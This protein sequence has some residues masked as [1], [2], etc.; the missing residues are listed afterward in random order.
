MVSCSDFLDQEPTEQRSINEQ[1]S[2]KEL[3]DQAVN[4]LYKDLESLLSHRYFLYADL[5]GGNFTFAPDSKDNIIEVPKGAYDQVYDFD[6]KQEDSDYESFYEGAYDVINAANLILEHLPVMDFIGENKLNQIQAEVLVVRGFA[7]YMLTLLYA[8]NYGYTQDASHK[9]VV[10]NT[11][12][13]KAGV[14][15]PQRETLAENWEHIQADINEAL[16]L[17]TMEQALGYG[18]QYSYFNPNNTKALYAKMALQM[19]N[20]EKAYSFAN[21]VISNSGVE[22][23]AKEEL[24]AE[25]KKEAEPVSE[26]LLEFS[27]SRDGDGAIGYSVSAY[28]NYVDDENYKR[29]VASDDLL[30]LYA[31]NDI[32]SDLF[33]EVEIETSVDSVMYELPYYFTWKFQ[34]EPGTLYLR[35]TEMYFIRAE[36]LARLGTDMNAALN[37]LNTIRERA[38]LEALPST[39]NLLEE[40]FME[41]RREL[42]FEGNLFF[43]IVRYKKDVVRNEGCLSQICNMAYPS[44]YFVLPIPEMSVTLNENMIQNDGY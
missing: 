17:F 12:T 10:Y 29:I 28:F 27:A 24:I 11:K 14:D 18:P 42:A 43:D 21:E 23:M 33:L 44:N 3:V 31:E 1:F 40:L 4:G 38:G 9:G 15:Y 41:R 13:L 34:G 35:L 36:A 30:N 26:V 7:H 32:R 6:D 5:V 19:N 16:Q 2:N 8:Q 37:D 39:N 25:W 22:L 20:W